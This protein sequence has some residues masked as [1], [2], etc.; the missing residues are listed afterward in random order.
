MAKEH[1]INL[2]LAHTQPLKI[3]I[4]NTVKIITKYLLN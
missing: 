2:L 1:G 4:S 3:K